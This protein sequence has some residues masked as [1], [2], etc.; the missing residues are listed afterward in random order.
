MQALPKV[1][2]DMGMP[3]TPFTASQV[4]TTGDGENN[5]NF[6]QSATNTKHN[7]AGYQ[8]A[9]S[10]EERAPA[11]AR[12]GSTKVTKPNQEDA[13]QGGEEKGQRGRPAK[14]H[15]M[16][17]GW[18]AAMGTP[19]APQTPTTMGN[20]PKFGYNLRPLRPT[21]FG[22]VTVSG[23][24]VCPSTPPLLGDPNAYLRLPPF[25]QDDQDQISHNFTQFPNFVAQNSPGSV[26]GPPFG[27]F[28]RVNAQQG[29]GN[30]VGLME[31]RNRLGGNI[32]PNSA[33]K[34]HVMDDKRAKVLMDNLPGPP[35]TEVPSREF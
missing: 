19:K 29:V 27:I 30:L 13:N 35:P 33:S 28:P 2:S 23:Q 15:T 32:S 31:V 20:G 17:K 26:F 34:T 14:G 3:P 10:N 4:P 24:T 5:Y 22:P 12:L 25:Q 7:M 6:L 11:W 8:A 16:A 9:M 21:V 18:R 1:F